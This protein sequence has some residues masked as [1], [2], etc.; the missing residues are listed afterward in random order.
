MWGPMAGIRYDVLQTKLRCVGVSA[1]F[2]LAACNQSSVRPPAQAQPPASTTEGGANA[3]EA[4][5]STVTPGI[6]A[7]REH[8]CALDTRGTV[9]C[10]GSN[11]HGQAKALGHEY[12]QIAAGALHTCAL[13]REG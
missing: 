11:M 2:A 5:A 8:S 10:W 9:E 6:A 12:K 1:L 13:S 7:G 3:T 4:G